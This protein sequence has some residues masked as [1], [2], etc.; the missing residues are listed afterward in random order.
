MNEEEKQPI[1]DSL[2]D[3]WL[4]KRVPRS[5]ST[6][7]LARQAIDPQRAAELEQALLAASVDAR[8]VTLSTMAASYRRPKPKATLWRV[9]ATLAAALM[10]C[11]GLW[12][13]S[14]SPS[15]VAV[16]QPAVTDRVAV[17]GNATRDAANSFD[18]QSNKDQ[19]ASSE[20][21]NQSIVKEN[22][23]GEKGKRESL[24]LDALPFSTNDAT[25][26]NTSR[27]KNDQ[28]ASIKLDDRDVVA[29]IDQQMQ[30][31][32]NKHDAR[33]AAPINGTAWIH[34]V[35]QQLLSRTPTQ[36]ESDAFSKR[37]TPEARQ[38]VL[39]QLVQSTE[40]TQVWSKRL[41]AFLVR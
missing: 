6:V 33:P 7:D 20:R 1:V 37:D 36:E 18:S 8:K 2:L 41:A 40:F 16:Q 10:I 17:Q 9:L 5:L 11:V 4:A 38:E 34:R 12:K 28:P 13:F 22:P 24:S 25:T 31:I 39:G 29:V 30:Q 3:E 14:N 21:P 23:S 15:M 32:W 35:T 19:V 27:T 26:A